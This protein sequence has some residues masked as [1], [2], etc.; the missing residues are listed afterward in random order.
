MTTESGAR[1]MGDMYDGHRTYADVQQIRRSAGSFPVELIRAR[2]GNFDGIEPPIR[3]FSPGIV[4]ECVT[5]APVMTV[6]YGTGPHAL[7]L[8]E[9]DCYVH[10]TMTETR[11]HMEG[12][13]ILLSIA[14]PFD[15]LAAA[16]EM[17]AADLEQSVR[18]L[19]NRLF[20]DPVYRQ[21]GL[22]MWDAAVDDDP[23]AGLLIDH[24]LM[25]MALRA[26]RAA[27]PETGE[28]EA[29]GPIDA[30]S[31]PLDD[32]RMRRVVEH[33][34]RNVDRVITIADLA[35]VAALSP[36]HFGRRFQATFAETP[37]RYVTRRRIEMAKR[38]MS[39][40][41]A[42]LEGVARACGFSSHSHLTRVFKREVGVTPT[43]WRRRQL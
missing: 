18:P 28:E 33:I 21:L 15:G 3:C 19:Y 24:C 41:G 17:D 38:M 7:S 13:A 22:D 37:H 27:R 26:I 1:P 35:D 4:L 11:W 30:I 39:A 8:A 34:E 32:A 43:T 6:D 20:V 36:W 14:V 23:L 25:T 42:D 9:G 40:R 29:S 12:E 16:L 31:A 2:K 5:G 10:P